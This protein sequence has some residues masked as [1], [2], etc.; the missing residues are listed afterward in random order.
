MNSSRFDADY[1]HRY[2]VSAGTRVAE[3][4]Y[5]DRMSGFM[6]AYLDYLGCEIGTVLDAGCGAGLLHAGLRRAWP[7]VSIH[8]F[9]VSAWACEE[10][11]WEHASLEEFSSEE[12]YDLVIC[13]DVVQYLPRQA[14]DDAL[15][16][17]A[18]LTE[19]ALFFGVLTT[20]DWRE[21]CDRERTDGDAHLRSTEWYARRLKKY[22]HN[23]GGGLFIRRGADV[24]LYSLE[25]F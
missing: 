22:F 7:G 9:D 20:E 4:A 25:R 16:K 11:G 24:V 17:L 21:N 3:P 23:V 5:F 19:T 10:Y 8:G 15:V 18:G 6:A 13:H 12:T 2:Y 1:Y 14:A